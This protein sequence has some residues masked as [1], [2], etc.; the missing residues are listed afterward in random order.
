VSTNIYSSKQEFEFSLNT[1]KF[2]L[3]RSEK[4]KKN[5]RKGKTLCSAETSSG[6]LNPYP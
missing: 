3:K 1:A 5:K 2:D 4:K 6:P